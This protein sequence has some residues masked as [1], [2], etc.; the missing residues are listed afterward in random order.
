MREPLYLQLY[1]Q[2]RAEIESGRLAVGTRL[3]SIRQ[4]TQECS[5]SRTTVETAYEHLCADGM[6]TCVPQSGYYVNDVPG[7]AAPS[8]RPLLPHK[9][10]I[11][12]NLTLPDTAW[13]R[14]CLILTFGASC[15]A[16]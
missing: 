2:L 10:C 14:R 9:L 11:H 12:V 16:L 5:V 6:V 4:M 15:P 8:N 7:T 3:P 13:I 1:H